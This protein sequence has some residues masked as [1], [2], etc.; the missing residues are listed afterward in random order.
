MQFP[1]DSIGTT[2]G[3]PVQREMTREVN[4]SRLSLLPHSPIESDSTVASKAKAAS[5][6]LALRPCLH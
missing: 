4:K 6:F 2:S 5:R 1:I 3:H